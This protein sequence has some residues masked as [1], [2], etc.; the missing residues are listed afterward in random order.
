MLQIEFLDRLLHDFIQLNWQAFLA[1][2][3]HGKLLDS[4]DAIENR[5]ANFFSHIVA[6][7]LQHGTTPIEIEIGLNFKLKF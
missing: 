6:A 2:N 1:L 4:N 5:S 7:F 3:I